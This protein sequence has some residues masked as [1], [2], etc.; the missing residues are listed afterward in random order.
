MTSLYSLHQQFETACLPKSAWTHEAHLKVALSMLIS[1]PFDEALCH[2]RAGIILLNKAHQTLNTA[3]AG[4]HETLTQF[5]ATVINLFL[6]ENTGHTA[7]KA[8]CMFLESGLA[9]KDLPFHFYEKEQLLNT[10]HRARF[11][12]P[13]KSQLNWENLSKFL[14]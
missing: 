9:S 5:W 8:V 12:P 10:R 1:Y 2:L 11:I 14:V 7:E 6:A 4:Y 13:T 3:N